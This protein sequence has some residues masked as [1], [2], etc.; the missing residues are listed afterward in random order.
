ME[1]G[2]I[3]GFGMP[4]FKTELWISNICLFA[5]LDAFQF[6]DPQALPRV[7]LRCRYEANPHAYNRKKHL[8]RLNAPSHW[9]LDKLSGKYAPRPSPGMFRFTC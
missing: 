6:P 1:V 7:S 4:D 9:L 5:P 3:E 8:K 2:S